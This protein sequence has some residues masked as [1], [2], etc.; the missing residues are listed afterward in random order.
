MVGSRE[1][2]APFDMGGMRDAP[3]GLGIAGCDMPTDCG[4]GCR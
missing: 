3:R 4:V 2:A 1:A